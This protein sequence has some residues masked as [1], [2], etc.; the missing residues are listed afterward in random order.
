MGNWKSVTVRLKEEDVASL[1][2]RLAQAGYNTL[3]EMARAFT[4]GI[5][6][7]NQ[8][9][10]PL[11]DAI[12]DRIV[13]KMSTLSESMEFP[14]LN[15]PHHTA[16][17]S[18]PVVQRYERPPCTRENPPG[19]QGRGFNS[20]P[21]HLSLIF[22]KRL[23]LIPSSGTTRRGVV[24]SHRNLRCFVGHAGRRV[25][26]HFFRTGPATV[27]LL[28]GPSSCRLRLH[29][30]AAAACVHGDGEGSKLA[31]CAQPAHLVIA[32][33]KTGTAIDVMTIPKPISIMSSVEMSGMPAPSTITLRRA[34][35][36]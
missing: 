35:V 17:L 34:S 2:Q 28:G 20:P 19:S 15:T 13:V 31:R 12:A 24:I 32:R 29:A 33:L 5:L 21:V 1:N 26:P 23:D 30:T 27:S 7:N 25:T 10:E 8:L 11:A 14:Q 6:T 3:G 22:A 4:Q 16:H 18:G 36:A 9:V